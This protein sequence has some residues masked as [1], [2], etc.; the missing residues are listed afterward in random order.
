MFGSVSLTHIVDL[1]QAKV[2]LVEEELHVCTGRFKLDSHE[3]L[4]QWEEQ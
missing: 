4:P 3:H 1:G 2:F